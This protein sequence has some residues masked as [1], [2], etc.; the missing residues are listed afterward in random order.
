[1]APPIGPDIFQS[2]AVAI[3]CDLERDGFQIELLDDGTLCISPRTGLTL[4]RMQEITEHRDAL[5]LLVRCCDEEVQD[6][7]DIFRRQI[8]AAPDGRMP[9]FIYREGVPYQA[10]SCFSCGADL[11]EP[12]FG[13]CWRCALA[14]RLACRLPVPLDLAD[15]IDTAKVLA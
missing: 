3:L 5:R 6:R 7:Q 14:W 12:V 9:V 8:A 15:V 13:R 11:P 2:P 4:E 1:M 10:G